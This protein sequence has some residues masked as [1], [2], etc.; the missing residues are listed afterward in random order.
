MSVL[1][2]V[3]NGDI[4]RVNRICSKDQYNVQRTTS[5]VQCSPYD[6]QRTMSTVRCPPYHV[7]STMSSIRC[8]TYNVRNMSR[9]VR[10]IVRHVRNVQHVPNVL[11]P[12]EQR[13]RPTQGQAG[14]ADQARG[15]LGFVRSF[16]SSPGPTDLYSQ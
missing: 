4:Q 5:N 16:C 3:S 14:L 6:V 13:S 2:L 8:P 15:A 12:L 7:H 1:I 11:G 10:N 9:N